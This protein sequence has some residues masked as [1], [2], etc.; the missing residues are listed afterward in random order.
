MKTPP[1]RRRSRTVCVLCSPCS[2]IGNL[3]LIPLSPVPQ[4][5]DI[6]LTP[7]GHATSP[8]SIIASG[9]RL[10]L[11]GRALSLERR[12]RPA[13][14]LT[15][16]QRTGCWADDREATLR[17]RFVER[18]TLRTA[19][20]RKLACGAVRARSR[21]LS[22]RSSPELH[23]HLSC[24]KARVEATKRAAQCAPY[25]VAWW[26]S[27]PKI[28]FVPPRGTREGVHAPCVPLPLAS[29]RGRSCQCPALLRRKR[30]SVR[31]PRCAA[32][33]W[34]LS[35][36][37]AIS[38]IYGRSH[39]QPTMP[40]TLP[41]A[42]IDAYAAYPV[43]RTSSLLLAS[44]PALRRHARG[45]C[46]LPLCEPTLTL[47]LTNTAPCS[48]RAWP[49]RLPQGRRPPRRRLGLD[50]RLSPRGAR[51]LYT[52]RPLPRRGALSLPL[53]HQA[54]SQRRPLLPP[55]V[56]LP[57]A[58]ARPRRAAPEG[59]GAAAGPRGAGRELRGRPR[60]GHQEV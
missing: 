23:E 53:P 38:L 2:A 11:A 30:S 8:V 16:R 7:T 4:L 57:V 28:A 49:A 18:G 26:S 19:R 34:S 24:L 35:L 13:Q 21:R 14:S 15:C 36:L 47:Q 59:G 39:E 25:P 29:A 40:N 6:S 43:H 33:A 32:V 22:G 12:R 51:L 44:L 50:A 31:K 46:G 10:R 58:R 52:R 45:R 37:L 27:T 41:P 3:R 42:G 1:R 56:A 9:L 55:R 5:A 60:E 48:G 20:Q 17:T 54:R